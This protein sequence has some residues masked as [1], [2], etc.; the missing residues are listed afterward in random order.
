MTRRWVLLLALLGG[1][2]AELEPDP[3]F[4]VEGP[5]RAT[6]AIATVGKT[7]GFTP[8]TVWWYGPKSLSCD[9]NTGFDS[10]TGC[11]TGITGT[12]GSIVLTMPGSLP[13]HTDLVH[14]LGH[15]AFGDDDHSRAD[16][17][18]PGGGWDDWQPG[19]KVG[20]MNAAIAAAGM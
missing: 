6:E 11:R 19:S 16:V 12:N 10:P 13:H 3:A 15:Q 9:S 7:W 18:G 17:W 4:L 8:R 20:D 14:E 5:P 2:A 1:C